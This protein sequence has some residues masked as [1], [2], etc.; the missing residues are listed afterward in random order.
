MSAHYCVVR[1]LPSALAEE[2]VNVGV[3][4][5]RGSTVRATFLDD[6]TRAEEFGGRSL[7]PARS[8]QAWIERYQAALDEETIRLVQR[9]WKGSLRLSEPRASLLD[10]EALLAEI[11]PTFLVKTGPKED[12]MPVKTYEVRDDGESVTL[13]EEGANPHLDAGPVVR[14][15]T[16]STPEEAGA[17]HH[18]AM[19]WQPYR[20]MGAAQPCPRACGAVYYPE[21]SGVCPTC[22]PIG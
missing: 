14:T 6:W 10:V 22:G 13:Q 21:G 16:A 19:G 12:P 20:P 2:F 5:F 8:F 15:F 4:A 9:N 3:I 1:F 17:K 18:E 11:A 7:A